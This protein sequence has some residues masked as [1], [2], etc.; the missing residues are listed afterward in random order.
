MKGVYR[1]KNPEKYKGD[2]TNI[3]YRS[4]YEL[5]LFMYLDTHPE[6]VWWQSEEMFIPYRSP[7]D[8]RVHRYFP[9]VVLRRAD[10]KTV[11]I[12]VKPQKDTVPPT[13]KSLKNGKP[14]KQYLRE[15]ME[16]GKNQAKWDAAREYCAD[17]DWEFL[18]FTER[19]LN[20]PHRS[21]K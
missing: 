12:E 4:S 18:I 2:P 6:I 19:E 1:P 10:G 15:V 8:R 9:D 21:S 14:S 17:R 16:W 7:L 3:I 13:K 11:M 20:I 5:K